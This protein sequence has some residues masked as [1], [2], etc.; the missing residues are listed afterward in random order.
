[1]NVKFPI[2]KEDGTE[3]REIDEIRT[4]LKQETGGFYLLG[5]HNTWHGGIH[6]TDASAPWCVDKHPIRSIAGGEIVAYRQ[7]E[8]CLQS[9]LLDKSLEYSNNFCLIKHKLVKDEVTFPFYSLYMHLAPMGELPKAK[10]YEF[11]DGIS[12]RAEQPLASTEDDGK[13]TY[14]Y[15]NSVEKVKLP[16]K[17]VV[18]LV[19]EQR[20]VVSVSGQE[21]V[22]VQVAV[23]TDGVKGDN[24]VDARKGCRVWLPLIKV[25]DEGQKGFTARNF[26]EK[27][28]TLPTWLPTEKERVKFT[29]SMVM[30]KKPLSTVGNSGYPAAGSRT[31]SSISAGTEIEYNSSDVQTLDFNGTPRPAVKY[32]PP[33]TEGSGKAF[34][35]MY[36]R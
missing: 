2:T 36:F 25:G 6:I 33:A 30:R 4:L 28:F 17:E 1:M 18:E 26:K 29:C 35:G 31:S 16:K 10:R 24:D 27:T 19:D 20:R 11:L 23:L 34:M 12:V 13:V 3:F 22:Y 21:Y 32:L 15:A 9:Q 5:N 14:S 7:S 8:Q